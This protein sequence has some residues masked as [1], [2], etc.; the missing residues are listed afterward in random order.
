M[1]WRH[2]SFTGKWLFAP[3]EFQQSTLK[4]LLYCTL[5]TLV[6]WLTLHQHSS[7]LI[8]TSCQPLCSHS[9]S[10]RI[11]PPRVQAQQ[12]STTCW[13]RKVFFPPVSVVSICLA[14]R[15]TAA[16]VQFPSHMDSAWGTIC[17]LLFASMG[18]NGTIIFL[19]DY[20]LVMEGPYG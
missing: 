16:L 10:T 20:P 3:E 12:M 17:P 7:E 13:S 19:T 15:A 9:S 1:F 14:L 6:S 11:M 2:L 8:S 18:R 5:S 4:V